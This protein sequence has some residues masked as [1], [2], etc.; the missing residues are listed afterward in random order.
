MTRPVVL[1]AAMLAFA[2]SYAN[3][4]T[5]GRISGRVVDQTDGPLPAV[6]IELVV[7]SKEVTTSTDAAGTYRFETVPAGQV[8]L[9]YRLLNFSVGRRTI[10]V[11][12]GGSV[13]LS[14]R[15]A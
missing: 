5:C 3:A 14:S 10:M 4:Q 7:H 6:S 8:E 12:A 11:V 1:V 13:K 2:G 15:C 9:T